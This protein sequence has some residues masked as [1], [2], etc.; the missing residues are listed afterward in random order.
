MITYNDVQKRMANSNNSG[1]GAKASGGLVTILQAL[2]IICKIIDAN[3][4]GDWPWWKVMLPLICSV[5]LALLICCCGVS[6]ICCIETIKS[7]EDKHA[8]S[9]RVIIENIPE[10]VP[11]VLATKVTNNEN[12]V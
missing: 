6:C 2:F 4:I 8:T 1:G 7:K 5:G 9:Q 11:V 3:V 10:D 12:N